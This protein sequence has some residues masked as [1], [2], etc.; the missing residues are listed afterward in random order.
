[1][2]DHAFT[3]NIPPRGFTHRHTQL[4]IISLIKQDVD[5]NKRKMFGYVP[6]NIN[7]Q[8]PDTKTLQMSRM[9]KTFV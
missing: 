3:G 4:Y 1:M 8:I 7:H 5:R 6:L 2:P 9:W